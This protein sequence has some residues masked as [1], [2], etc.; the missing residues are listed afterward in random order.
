MS[1]TNNEIVS[2]FFELCQNRQKVKKVLVIIGIDQHRS[3]MLDHFSSTRNVTLIRCNNRDE[4]RKYAAIHAENRGENPVVLVI[5]SN[6]LELKTHGF[7]K[8][9]C[10]G[11]K[12]YTKPLYKEPIELDIKI[13]L[14][15]EGTSVNTDEPSMLRRFDIVNISA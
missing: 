12:I 8:E 11:D 4:I 1:L 7:I 14:I 5:S 10:G 3:E 15:I 2:N 6:L 9:I 13:N